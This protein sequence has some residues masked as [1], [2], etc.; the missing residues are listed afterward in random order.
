MVPTSWP[1][2]HAAHPWGIKDHMSELLLVHQQLYVPERLIASAGVEVMVRGQ[3]P[4][5][6]LRAPFGTDL[7]VCSRS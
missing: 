5:P 3:V 4:S 7:V 2:A 1:T 6:A